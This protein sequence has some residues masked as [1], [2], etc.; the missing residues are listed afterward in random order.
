L[1][2][3]LSKIF[4]KRVEIVVGSTSRQKKVLII[5]ISLDEAN[6]IL[7]KYASK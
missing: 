3:E 1:I 2:K 6:S 7:A 5:G 4:K